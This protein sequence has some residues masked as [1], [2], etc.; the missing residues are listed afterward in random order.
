VR[1]PFPHTLPP[2]KTDATREKK[3]PLRL[4]R[5][6]ANFAIQERYA[7]P[8]EAEV[9]WRSGEYDGLKEPHG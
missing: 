6:R 1:A 3:S 9:R 5:W 2:S 7:H 8:G 4:A